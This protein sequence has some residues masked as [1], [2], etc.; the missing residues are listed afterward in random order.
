MAGIKRGRG[1]GNLVCARVW[2]RALI[3]FPFPFEHLPRGL[4][5]VRFSW[6]KLLHILG[7]VMISP[8]QLS[9]LLAYII[10]ISYTYYRLSFTFPVT[11]LLKLCIY[12]LK[13]CFCFYQSLICLTLSFFPFVGKRRNG[14]ENC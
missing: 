12:D 11:N 3:P 10:S 1:R 2:S 6:T 14:L 9:C 4:A 7:K 5:E 13:I 8:G